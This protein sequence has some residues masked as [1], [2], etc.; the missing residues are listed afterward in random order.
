MKQFLPVTNSLNKRWA[1]IRRYSTFLFFLLFTLAFQTLQAQTGEALN[2]DGVNDYVDISGVPLSGSYTKEA[3]I[4]LPVVDATDP[5]AHNIISGAAT[6]LYVYQGKLGAGHNFN[7]VQDPTILTAKT[8]YHVAVTF[9]APTG[10]MVLYKNGFPVNVGTAPTYTESAL[11]LGAIYTGVVGYFFNGTM[12]QVRIWNTARTSTQIFN[13]FS[14]YVSPTQPN[15]VALY[16]FTQGI[17]NGNNAGVTILGD[18]TANSYNGTLM[19]FAL[20]GT[21]SNW[22]APGAPLNGTCVVLSVQLSN[23]SVEKLSNGVNLHWQT[24]TEINNKGFEIQ[25]SIDGINS[26]KDVA[27]VA[28]AGNTNE[29]QS[30]SYTDLV[31]IKGNN[32]YRLKQINFDGEVTYSN[33]RTIRIAQLNLLSIYPTLAQSNVTVEVGSVD[34][35]NTIISVYDG[36]GRMV[37]QDRLTSQ[38]QLI[39][40]SNLQKGMYLIK[41]QNGAS[42]RFVKL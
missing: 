1:I 22:V 2:F 6:S 19:N 18:S 30:Y 37:Q 38:K 25:R 4:Y 9:D 29:K 24:A 15:L 41:L 20:T 7:N 17:A 21:T 13:D 33:V 35:I 10:T 26:W 12:D 16:P 23:F 40:I 32:Y 5:N 28:G 11:Y 34:M 27:F 42:E 39:N 31:P 3:W 36:Q 8:W 14:C